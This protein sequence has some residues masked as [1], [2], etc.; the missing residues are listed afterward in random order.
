MSTDD[1]SHD[2]Y[3]PEFLTML[4]S[5]WGDGFLSPG[6]PDAVDAIVAGL[7]LDGLTVL[8]IGSGLGGPALHLA[9]TTGAARIVGTEV[10][11]EL[12]QQA[13]DTA[14][15][16]GLSGRVDFLTVTPGPL[17]FDD[18]AFDVV[19]SKDSIIHV[20]DKAALVP[21]IHRVLKPGGKVAIGD[22]FGGTAPLSPEA[23]KWL[24]ASGLTF[25]LKP[26][27]D[28][29][30]LFRNAGFETVS[31]EDRNAWYAQEIKREVATL[32]GEAGRRLA[33]AIGEDAAEDWH[34][35]TANRSVV[36]DQ[37]HLR[38]GHVRARKP[39]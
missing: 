10:Q 16:T 2:V 15:R 13:G 7:D 29:A 5:I 34:Q 23:E 19:F 26:I 9:K 6:G 33:A 39:V 24:V 22:W 21:E 36:V 4:Q 8:D 12:V 27:D 18:E 11:P 14:E 35:R 37:G 3:S 31:A 32:E 1:D 28:F 30:D 17:P 25:A 38:P 20:A